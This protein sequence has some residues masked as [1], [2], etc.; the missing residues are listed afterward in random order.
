M[1]YNDFPINFP[2]SIVEKLNLA[3][4]KK[5][6]ENVEIQKVNKSIDKAEVCELSPYQIDAELQNLNDLYL[7]TQAHL[8]NIHKQDPVNTFVFR[9]L[10]DITMEQKVVAENCWNHHCNCD[11]NPPCQQP[12]HNSCVDYC[13]CEMQL[14]S[15]IIFLL[16]LQNCMLDKKMFLKLL[17]SRMETLSKVF[18][19]YTRRQ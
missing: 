7:K 17:N 8:E 15:K 6:S 14:I 5:L 12:F 19:I 2:D 13:S 4:D 16:S 3:Y 9:A 1:K 10:E 18:N 11:F